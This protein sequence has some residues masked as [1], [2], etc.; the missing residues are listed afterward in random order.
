[1]GDSGSTMLGFLIAFLSLDFYRVHHH[2]GSHWLLPLVFA[3]LPL[4]D[5]F[6][7]VIRR[8]RKRISPFAGDRGHFYDLLLDRGWSSL[9]V[10]LGAYAV[11]GALLVIGWLCIHPD[12][13]ISVLLLFV[14]AFLFAVSLRN[15]ESI[16]QKSQILFGSQQSSSDTNASSDD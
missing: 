1:M 13:K 2:I 9:H 7:A 12:W 6:L 4:M 3:A 8:L 10:A 16:R 11:T 15:F 14:V 5:F